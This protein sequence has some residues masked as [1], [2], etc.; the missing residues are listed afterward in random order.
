MRRPQA[1]EFAPLP[2]YPWLSRP[3]AVPL[4]LEEVETAIFMA[5]GDI[6]AAADRLKVPTAMLNR[7]VR[8]YP[9]LQ[10]LREE[11][12]AISE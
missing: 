3:E 5:N 6:K 11:L 2:F 7:F 9:R 8:K 10:R 12:A 1:D 4:R